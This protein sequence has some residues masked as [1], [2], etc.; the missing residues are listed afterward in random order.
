MPHGKQQC[1]YPSVCLSPFQQCD[2]I[3][4]FTLWPTSDLYPQCDT[5]IPMFVHRAG[6]AKRK[7]FSLLFLIQLHNFVTTIPD[8]NFVSQLP[9]TLLQLVSYKL[10]M[11]GVVYSQKTD[12][13]IEEYQ[14]ALSLKCSHAASEDWQLTPAYILLSSYDTSHNTFVLYF[15]LLCTAT[16]LSLESLPRC[17]RRRDKVDF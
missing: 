17:Y 8:G 14:C 4:L 1:S 2:T 5:H 7:N 9:C 13:N 10:L 15:P 16:H 6:L 11:M 12:A 3:N